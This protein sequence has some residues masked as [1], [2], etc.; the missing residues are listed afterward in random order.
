MKRR[1]RRLVGRPPLPEAERRRNV[2]K[3]RLTD[4][5][6]RD[7]P[8]ATRIPSPTLM[9]RQGTEEPEAE[10]AVAWSPDSR[11]LSTIRI[12]SRGAGTLSMVQHAPIEKV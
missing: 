4:D 9:V 2:A 1:R 8:W 10:V 7:W 6:T 12:S 5:G 3:I 11:R